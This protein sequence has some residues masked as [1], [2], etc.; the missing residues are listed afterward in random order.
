MAVGSLAGWA[1]L[2][3]TLPVVLAAAYLWIA[4]LLLSRRTAALGGILI[5]LGACWLGLTVAAWQGQTWIWAVFSLALL[6]I[7]AGLTRRTLRKRAEPKA[8]TSAYRHRTAI[9]AATLVASL[10]LGG[11]GLPVRP[12]EYGLSIVPVP[13]W[14]SVSCAGY[15]LPST[16]VRGSP[17]DPRLAWLEQSVEVPGQ[18]VT[19][20]RVEATWPEGYRARFTS[21]LEILDGWGNVVFHDGDAVEGACGQVN[22]ADYLVPP[23]K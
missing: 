12:G 23:F 10:A 1:M 16:V 18:A 8:G 11:F 4:C 22:G 13:V 17:N 20:Q 5:G 21:H 9:V 19:T 7:G 15:G 2:T 14:V 6:A 3:Q